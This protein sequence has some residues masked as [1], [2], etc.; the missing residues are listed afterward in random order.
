MRVSLV[1]GNQVRVQFS[2]PLGHMAGAIC[3]RIGGMLER[4]FHLRA[5]ESVDAGTDAGVSAPLLSGPKRNSRIVAIAEILCQPFLLLVQAFVLLLTAAVF[6]VG[7]IVWAVWRLLCGLIRPALILTSVAALIGIGAVGGFA[8]SEYRHLSPPEA[9]D[10]AAPDDL[11]QVYR[12][13]APSAPGLP[14]PR[15]SQ[16]PSLPQAEEIFKTPP[17]S[18]P[19]PLHR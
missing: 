13:P 14:Q 15:T 12:L 19:A 11:S 10:H 9:A 7:L 17:A 4:L 5:V 1:S 16:P 18:V 2:G 8:Y 3:A 6:L